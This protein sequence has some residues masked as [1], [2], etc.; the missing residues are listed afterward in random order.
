MDIQDKTKEELTAEL[1]SAE[2]AKR[3]A[4]LVIANEEKA[5]RI[6]SVQK[7]LVRLA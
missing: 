1:A 6:K 2:K 4:E 3:E 5:V 7:L